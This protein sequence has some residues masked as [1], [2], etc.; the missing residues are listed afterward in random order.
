MGLADKTAN[1]L[2]ALTQA[3]TKTKGESDD[4]PDPEYELPPTGVN[5]LA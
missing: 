1:P 3:Q 2:E 5:A 4:N